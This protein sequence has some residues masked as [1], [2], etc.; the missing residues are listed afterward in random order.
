MK[1]KYYLVEV[2]KGEIKHKFIMLCACLI[3]TY[4]PSILVIVSVF[5][6]LNIVFIILVLRQSLM[7][8]R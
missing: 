4:A 1:A 8:S 5:L 3:V 6:A 7:M 2:A